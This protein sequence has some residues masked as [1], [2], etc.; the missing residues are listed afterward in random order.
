MTILEH[1]AEYTAEAGFSDL[2]REDREALRI[3]FL[4]TVGAFLCAWH[5]AEGKALL[6]LK[7]RGVDANPRM[8]GDCLPDKAMFVSAVTRSSEIDDIHLPSCVTPGSVIVPVALAFAGES[9][10]RD[11][12][13]FRDALVVGYEM[14]VRLGMAVRGPEILYRG[15]WPTYYCAAFGAAATAS[16]ML[17]LSREQ[18]AHALSL[19]L[20]LTTGGSTK[21]KGNRSIRWI[22]LGNAVRSGCLAAFAA[23]DG[24]TGDPGMLDDDWIFRVHGL[25]TDMDKLL[26]NLGK[27]SVIGGISLKPYCSA[28]Q[29]IA[30][31]HGLE[32]ILK[33]GVG[34]EE[35]EAVEV[36]V[37]ER[38]LA[39]INHGIDPGERLSTV[40]SAPYQLAL[41]AH[42]PEVLYDDDRQ[43]PPQTLEIAAF[44]EK[45]RVFADESLASHYPERWP[46]RVA[47]RT[48]RGERKERTVL[49]APGDPGL[50]FG[51]DMLER[52][53]HRFLDPL[54]GPEQA[55]RMLA[56]AAEAFD[57]AARLAELA[58]RIDDMMRPGRPNID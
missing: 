23:R 24:F 36:H 21:V 29:V 22:T 42:L 32:E 25:L 40:T 10:H 13:T 48:R 4:D 37:P 57:D 30:A 14:M 17:R 58:G 15:I 39:M 46:A 20:C 7:A 26:G 9:E 34:P 31:I 41:A 16:R 55:E 38:Y 33:E 49:A 35:I 52:K 51:L 12:G 56:L 50:P 44:M 27:G 8:L 43:N 54:M 19:A 3:H 11:T 28:K 6:G 5:T 1:L 47:V 45:V 53:L 18:T 2:S